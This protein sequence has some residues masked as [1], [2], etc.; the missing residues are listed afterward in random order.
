MEDD[1]GEF[2]HSSK[3]GFFAEIQVSWEIDRYCLFEELKEHT[4]W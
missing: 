2:A 3:E 1:A 4:P